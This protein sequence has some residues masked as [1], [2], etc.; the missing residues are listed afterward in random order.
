MKSFWKNLSKPIFALAPLDEVTDTVFRRIVASVAKPDVMFT[1]FTSVEG[2]T[3]KGA[4]KVKHRLNFTPEEK[5]LIAQIWGKD[6]EAFTQVAAMV[7]ELG[8][9]G[10]DINMGC[11][12]RG[13]TKRGCCS[14][15]IDNPELAADII[16]A[17]K[18]G[19]GDLP[20]SVKTRC[21]FKDW[22]TEEWITFLLKQDIQC[23]TVHGRIAKEMSHFPAR[24]D[25]IAKAV[26]IRDEL[27][28]ETV[29]LGNGD[30]ISSEDAF[31]KIKQSGVDGVMIGRGIFHDQWIFNKQPKQYQPTIE[32]RLDLLLRHAQLFDEVWG[33]T[34]NFAILKKFF[35]AYL[36][37]F[38][39]AAEM[40]A[41]LMQSSG[42]DDVRKIVTR[43]QSVNRKS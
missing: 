29:I 28:V 37:D 3:S 35:K 23:L 10:V 30:V 21:G 14:A 39:G 5:P 38:D 1:E 32:E 31:A 6:L 40:R 41:E 13:I 24:W 2:L 20:V 17:V 16:A 22:K 36:H 4:D 33:N 27:G 9:D 26:Q 18:K 15:L 8:F 19:A 25:E 7:K 34:K 43:L 12:E 42:I 11:P